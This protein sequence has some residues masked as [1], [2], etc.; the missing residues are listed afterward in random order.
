MVLIRIYRWNYFFAP[1]IIIHNNLTHRICYRHSISLLFMANHPMYPIP[2]KNKIK[3]LIFRKE[4]QH[5][6]SLPKPQSFNLS[7]FHT[8]GRI[9]PP[10]YKDIVYWSVVVKTRRKKKILL[11]ILKQ[12]I[13]LGFQVFFQIGFLLSEQL[14]VCVWELFCVFRLFSF[15]ILH[16][17]LVY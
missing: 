8:L 1:S 6:N 4:R 14:L 9:L 12:R 2:Y 15:I 11:E 3:T 16:L 5:K 13:G 17:K 7:N 10:K